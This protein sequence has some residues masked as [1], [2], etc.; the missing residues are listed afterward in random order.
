MIEWIKK[1]TV[2]RGLITGIIAPFF[3]F[4]FYKIS[5]FNYW[6]L[7]QFFFRL[8]EMD[9]LAA[10]ISLSIIANGALFFLFLNRG[11]DNSSRGV[12]FATFIY[13]AVIIYLKFF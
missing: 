9:K 6:N 1:D 5:F 12:L 7:K 3:G 13:G 10:V 2:L 8:I 11:W 4:Y